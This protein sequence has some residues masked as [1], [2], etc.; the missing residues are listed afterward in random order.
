MCGDEVIEPLVARKPEADV[1][2][3]RL[4][5]GRLSSIL[6]RALACTLWSRGAATPDTLVLEALAN[7]SLMDRVERVDRF[8][9]DRCRRAAVGMIVV[10]VPVVDKYGSLPEKKWLSEVEEVVD[11]TDAVWARKAD[12]SR[13]RRLTL[14][15]SCQLGTMLLQLDL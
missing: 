10:D 1:E 4:T 6:G 3:C 15:S 14:Q 13:V 5:S 2:F 7:V 8:E 11:A 12:S 9:D